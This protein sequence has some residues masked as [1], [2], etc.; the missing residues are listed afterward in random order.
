MDKSFCTKV[1]KAVGSA[2]ENILVAGIEWRLK[3][4][5]NAVFRQKNSYICQPCLHKVFIER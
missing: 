5:I 4:N 1:K 3:N 2:G